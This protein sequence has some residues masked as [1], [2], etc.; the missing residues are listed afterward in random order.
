MLGR[1]AR[2]F[3]TYYELLEVPFDANAM[4]IKRAYYEKAKKLHPDVTQEQT[5]DEFKKVTEAY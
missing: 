2:R 4:E 3:K 1:L 5:S